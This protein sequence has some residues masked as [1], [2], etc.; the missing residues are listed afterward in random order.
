MRAS[1]SRGDNQDEWPAREPLS[2]TAAAIEVEVSPD[3]PDK[4]PRAF[5]PEIYF[6]ERRQF[7]VGCR[8]DEVGVRNENRQA[9]PLPGLPITLP[10][11][12][13]VTRLTSGRPPKGQRDVSGHQ[14]VLHEEGAVAGRS[15]R[16]QVWIEGASEADAGAGQEVAEAGRATARTADEPLGSPQE[17]LLPQRTDD[18]LADDFARE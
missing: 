15:T 3:L 8:V 12:K 7:E 18:P 5:G 2:P 6:E 16:R 4:E 11:Q 10:I 1:I 13:L 14:G 17:A 9:Q